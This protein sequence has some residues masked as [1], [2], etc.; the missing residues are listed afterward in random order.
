MG[1]FFEDM[2]GDW[3]RLHGHQSKDE[4]RASREKR[5]TGGSDH[6]AILAMT[7]LE[8]EDVMISCWE[9]KL[10]PSSWLPLKFSRGCGS[11]PT[12]IQESKTID[13]VV[14]KEKEGAGRHGR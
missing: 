13:V 7:E 3:T 12:M 4:E 11:R 14:E 8:A 10:K 9:S 2:N 1:S 5:H 6:G